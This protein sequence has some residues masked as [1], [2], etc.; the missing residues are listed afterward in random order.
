MTILS[1]I[2]GR[3][4][5]AQTTVA[6]SDPYLAEFL[7]QGGRFGAVDPTRASGLPVALRCITLTAELMASVPLFLY[8]TNDRGGRE[9]AN[10]H[11][12]YGVLHDAPNGV[13]TAFDFRNTLVVDLLVQ[14][15]AYAEITRNGRGQVAALR[16]VDPRAMSV[17]RLANGRL[18]YRE[19][20][21]PGKIFL[22]DEML[23]L[24]WR[25]GHDGI[26][27]VSPLQLARDAFGLA[28]SQADTAGTQAEKGFRPEGVLAFPQMITGAQRADLLAGL[29]EK[30]ISDASTSG[31]L[32][33]DGGI[34]WKP[35]AFS[36]KD[37]EFL[38]SRKL[39][40]LDI[41][42]VFGVP[43]SA[44]G[45][46]DNATYSNIGEESRALVQRCLAPMAKRIEQ[47]M[48]MALLTEESRKTFFVEHDL[49]GLLRGD[50]GARYEAYRIGRDGGWLSPNEIRR[51]ENLPEIDGGDE[52]LSPLNMQRIGQREG[53]Q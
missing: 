7:G 10:D 42:R 51:L 15:N 6:T 9:R 29:R 48:N 3:E 36:S 50:L 27:G 23:H 20:G 4:R 24:R 47:A 45:I 37:A 2:L 53:K 30:I 38:E 52:Y 22:Q 34:E 43:P 21:A 41:C 17:E 5:R 25:F 13:Q 31:I 35:M 39:S 49:A 16:R 19:S 26:M 8:R 28:M 12:L 14:G 18:R 40:N 11:P 33:L 1:R 46:T 32:V 44:A